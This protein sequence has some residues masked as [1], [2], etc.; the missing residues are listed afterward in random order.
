MERET[1]ELKLRGEDKFIVAERKFNYQ[2]RKVSVGDRIGPVDD[3]TVKDIMNRRWG[4]LEGGLFTVDHMRD[5]YHRVTF[6]GRKYLETDRF[7]KCE[8]LKAASIFPAGYKCRLR[9]AD[10][11]EFTFR[12]QDPPTAPVNCTPTIPAAWREPVLMICEPRPRPA[13]EPEE[14]AEREL[15]VAEGMARDANS[16]MG[17]LRPQN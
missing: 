7:Y 8:F 5:G 13:L 6:W 15:A 11:A 3:E 2:G 16:W 17:S 1:A 9:M 14:R 10:I 4:R 12:F